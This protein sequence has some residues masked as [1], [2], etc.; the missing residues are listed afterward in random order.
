MDQA[1]ELANQLNPDEIRN[2]IFRDDERHLHD[3]APCDVFLRRWYQ[4]LESPYLRAE[5]ADCFV[6]A[7]TT[8][9]APVPNGE[10][11]GAYMRTES[12]R[13]VITKIASAIL[14]PELKDLDDTPE[15]PLDAASAEK[16]R[17][18]GRILADIE[19]PPVVSPVAPPEEAETN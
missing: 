14:G 2:R 5:A 10:Y 17:A 7:Y 13:E 3:E 9:L 1:I 4:T 11:I 19:L 16:W 15:H 6:S 8:E 12:L 18:V